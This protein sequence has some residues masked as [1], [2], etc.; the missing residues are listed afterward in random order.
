MGALEENVRN[1][2]NDLLL[3]P[4]YCIEIL[5]SFILFCFFQ[6]EIDYLYLQI[7]KVHRSMPLDFECIFL[8]LVAAPG[9]FLNLHLFHNIILASIHPPIAPAK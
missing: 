6:T 8:H 9:P 3:S 1:F 5:L 4:I 2:N 7:K